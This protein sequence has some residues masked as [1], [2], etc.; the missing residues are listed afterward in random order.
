MADLRKLER[1]RAILGE[2]ADAR[3]ARLLLF[4]RSGFDRDVLDLAKTRDDV[5]LI[6]LERL[7]RGD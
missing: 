4:S 2:K 6:D 7:Y 3:S 5:D 1:G